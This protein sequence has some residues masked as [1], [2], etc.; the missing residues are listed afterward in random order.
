VSCDGQGNANLLGPAILTNAAVASASANA[1]DVRAGQT[2]WTV[3]I[4]LT[5]AGQSTWSAYTTAH[6]ATIE[7]HLTPLTTACGTSRPCANYVAFTL[8]GRADSIPLIEAPITGTVTRI[9][10][11]FTQSS[12]TSLASVIAGQPLDVPLVATVK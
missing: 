11:N 12:A 7:P 10:G 8:D 5:G 1:P 2:Q 9:S 3:A 6:N 4:T